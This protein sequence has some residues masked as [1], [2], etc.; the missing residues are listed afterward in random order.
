MFSR[1]SS[2]ERN[3]PHD[4]FIAVEKPSKAEGIG[5]ALQIAFRD[6]FELPVEMRTCLDLLNRITL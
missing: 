3:M 4:R 2:E 6:G 5:R 1:G